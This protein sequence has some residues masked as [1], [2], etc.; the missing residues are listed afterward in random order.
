MKF[1]E[2]LEEACYLINQYS[3]DVEGRYI[4]KR[5]HK[6]EEPLISKAKKIK[7]VK[8][9]KRRFVKKRC[10]M[11]ILIADDFQSNIELV[12]DYT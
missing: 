7:K 6:K 9:Y 12:S 8:K 3:T 5:K 1:E 10:V 11:R 2:A 4:K